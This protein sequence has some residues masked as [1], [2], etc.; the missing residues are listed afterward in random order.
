MLPFLALSTSC[1]S[2]SGF[3]ASGIGDFLTST[4]TMSTGF[5]SGFRSTE[6]SGR[7]TTG[8]GFGGAAAGLRGW[9]TLFGKM[10][11]ILPFS[12]LWATTP[13]LNIWFCEVA[14][15]GLPENDILSYLEG[16]STALKSSFDCGTVSSTVLRNSGS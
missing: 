8:V 5:F 14:V 6:R 9:T 2:G 13:F 10:S 1:R 11:W 7:G 3:G 15:F 16:P 12:S 4:G